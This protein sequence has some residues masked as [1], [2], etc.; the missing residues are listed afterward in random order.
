MAVPAQQEIKVQAA[1]IGRALDGSGPEGPGARTSSPRSS[2][3]SASPSRGGL[4]IDLGRPRAKRQVSRLVLDWIGRGWLRRVEKRDGRHKPRDYV[5]A[6]D[7]PV[8]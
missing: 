7:D 3:G 6:G 4:G 1:D 2:P 5:E 8:G